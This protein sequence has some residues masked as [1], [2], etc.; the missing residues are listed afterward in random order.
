M[1]I[2][3]FPIDQVQANPW[4]T[5]LEEDAEHIQQIAESFRENREQGRGEGG[6]LQVP[7]GRAVD[8]VVQLAFGMTRFAAWKIANPDLPFPIN[9]AELSDRE[10]SDLAA[11]E[12]AKRKNLNAIETATAIQRRMKEFAL[13]QVDAAKPFGYTAQG[14]ISNLLRLLKLPG[15]VQ[16]LVQEHKLAERNARALLVVERFDP[17]FVVP[18]A[19]KSMSADNPEEFIDQQ[20]A[21]L[22]DKRG[23]NL[24]AVPWELTWPKAPIVLPNPPAGLEQIPACDG[25]A[26]LFVR[27]NNA[28]WDK[29]VDRFC[30]RVEC[31]EKKMELVVVKELTR[32]AGETKI[33]VAQ[34]NERVNIVY[35]GTSSDY[36]LDEKVKRLV[37]ARTPELRLVAYSQ[38]ISRGEYRRCEVFGSEW[39]AL[40]TTDHAVTEAWLKSKNAEERKEIEMESRAETAEESE[41]ARRKRLEREEKEAAARRAER[42]AANKAKFDMLWLVE[43]IVKYC[44][45]QMQISGGVL[46]WASGRAHSENTI[47]QEWTELR[48]VESKWEDVIAEA[49]DEGPQAELAYRCDIALHLLY[50]E[51]FR[52]QK[53][54]EAY[55]W[56]RAQ[57]AVKEFVEEQMRLPLPRD[58]NK[59]P[60]HHT[61]FNCW[62]CGKFAPG[63]KLTKRDVEQD[64]WMDLGVDSETGE[65]LGTFCSENHSQQFH[66]NAWRAK[67]PKKKAREGKKKKSK[68]NGLADVDGEQ[69]RAS[70]TLFE[71]G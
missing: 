41:A 70:A 25:C 37:K 59:P 4:Q 10:M 19:E 47:S 64:G 30:C 21:D 56:T 51:I 20:I 49:K 3:T 50:A 18:I 29:S 12:N 1:N 13:T 28:R 60:I 2:K 38:T 23:R 39:V 15:P 66:D 27:K 53:I 48:A 67:Q 26:Y 40:A 7:M 9:I 32:V 11:E 43:T 58:W 35:D 36:Y 17:K 71:E 5:R 8:G 54:E 61:V 24:G 46:L 14:T 44:A 62:Q 34:P 63:E 69:V 68:S 16:A 22:L 31:F 57:D 55:R 52:W 6:M 65:L 45:S 42:C 33:P